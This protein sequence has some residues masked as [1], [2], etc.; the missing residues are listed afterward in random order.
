VSAVEELLNLELLIDDA[1]EIIIEQSSRDELHA[2][3]RVARALVALVDRD[4]KW[5]DVALHFVI[6]EYL[7]VQR[8]MHEWSS[9]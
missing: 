2:S 4:E 9:R 5:I 6:A 1:L 7:W 3:V 8:L